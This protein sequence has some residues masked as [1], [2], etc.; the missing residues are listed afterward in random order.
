MPGFRFDT[1]PN[2]RFGTR[3]IRSASRSR[4]AKR[5]SGAPL[6]LARAPGSPADGLE[7]NFKGGQ[8][9]APDYFALAGGLA[10]HDRA[11]VGDHGAIN[12][13]VMRRKCVAQDRR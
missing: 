5:R 11:V 10:A 4:S 7:L 6:C 12:P 9:G 2:E 1:L 13:R 3:W 8:V